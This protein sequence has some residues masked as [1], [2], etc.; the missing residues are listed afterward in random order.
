[1]VDVHLTAPG[2]RTVTCIMVRLPGYLLVGWR[3]LA[4]S[5]NRFAMVDLSAGVILLSFAYEV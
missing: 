3:W 5:T 2:M 1:M 4:K